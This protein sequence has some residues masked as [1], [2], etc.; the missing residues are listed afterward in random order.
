MSW[1]RPSRYH[2]QLH[3]FHFF[4][5]SNH[6]TNKKCHVILET[7]CN[8]WCVKCFSYDLI[9]L[10]EVI[11]KMAGIEV[12]E[13]ITN[14]QLLSMCGGELLRQE[15]CTYSTT[16]SQAE[17]LHKPVCII[18]ALN[19]KITI[20]PFMYE[21]IVFVTINCQILFGWQHLFGRNN[22]QSM[23]FFGCLAA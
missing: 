5:S 19:N 17:E 21:T 18:K 13:E 8:L 14:D 23:D 22:Y 9:I 6:F 20:S 15:V 1:T 2:Q 7:K 11:Q 16:L 3:N 10:R 12:S 4:A